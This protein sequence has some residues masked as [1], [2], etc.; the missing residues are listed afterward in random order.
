MVTLNSPILSLLAVVVLGTQVGL[1]ANR[2]PFAEPRQVF[3]IDAIEPQPL[4]KAQMAKAQVTPFRTGK[5]PDGLFYVSAK[6]RGV[7]VRFLVDTGA[8]IVVLTPEDARRIGVTPG[9]GG[10]SDIETAGGS[11]RIDRITLDRVS[12]AG[13]DLDGVDAAVMHDGLKVSLLGQNLLSKLG[14]VTITGD[15]LTLSVP[16]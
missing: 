7:P 12:I 9:S 4:P 8:N 5:S 11:S 6:V 1:A 3:N 13:R 16:R 15:E 2:P 14:P 10:G